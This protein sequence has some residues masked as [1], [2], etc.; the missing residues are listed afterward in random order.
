MSALIINN[1]VIDT[2]II[3][4]L[5]QVKKE[6]P[7]KILK[8]MKKM[9]E[10]IRVTCP[11]H[12]DGNEDHP[13]CNVYCG[14]KDDIEYGYFKCFTCSEQ[15][16]LY[17]FVGKCFGEDSDFGKEWLIERF[18]N[19]YIDIIKIED[20]IKLKK[21]SNNN[22]LNESILDNF[23]SYHPYMTQRKI[24]NKIIEMFKLKYDP[25]TKCIVFPVWDENNNL[26][27]LTRRSVENK[28]FII[29]KDADKVVYL[30]NF[31][32]KFNIKEC[33][34]AESQINA[35]YLWSIGIPAVALLG[36]GCKEQYNILNKSGIRVYYLYFDGD[37]AGDKGREKFIN[38]I[39]KDVIVSTAILPRGKDVNDLSVEE[40]DNLNYY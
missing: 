16:H 22:Y 24:S 38:N 6:S 7:Y 34:I 27:F 12:K 32:N 39:R 37:Q 13:S 10:D 28:K 25:K 35:L 26:V 20:E 21:N 23:Q 18:G 29:D 2:P 8:T 5:E 9:G 36:T 30:L 19:N 14:D 11:F 17:D 31:I 33:A 4:I 3:D 40:I 1:Y 15:G